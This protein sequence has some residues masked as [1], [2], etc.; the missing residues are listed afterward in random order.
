MSSS[1]VKPESPIALGTW[2]SAGS[3]VITEVAA[4]CGFDWLL[5]DLEHG[6][7]SEAVVPD[8]L[9]AMHGTATQAIVRVGS[10]DPALIGRLLDWGADG[11]MVPHVRSAEEAARCVAAMRYPPKGNRGITRS[12]RALRYGLEPFSGDKKPLLLTQIEDLPGVENAEAIAQVDGVDTLFVGPADLQFALDHTSQTDAPG[13]D[14]CLALV[15]AAARKHGKTTGILTRDPESAS[16]LV[17][18]GFTVIAMQSDIGILR[19]QYQYLVSSKSALFQGTR[20][21]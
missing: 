14:E 5:I 17:K 10:L 18:Q 12:G 13:F 16:G 15:V 11:I 9:R 20:D 7:A 2:M 6:S 19:K 1:L 8:Q 4:E 3:P 21:A